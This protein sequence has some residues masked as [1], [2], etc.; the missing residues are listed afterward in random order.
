MAMA[1]TWEGIARA[2][3]RYVVAVSGAVG[4]G[5]LGGGVWAGTTTPTGTVLVSVGGAIVAASALALISVTREDLLETLLREGVEYVFK[6]RRTYCN[7]DFWDS[8]L[9]STRGHYRVL[10]VANHAYLGTQPKKDRFE[11]LFRAAVI[12]GVTVELLWLNP[13][14]SLAEARESEEGRA[15]R[16]DITEAIL[17][18]WSLKN[19]LPHEANRR[20]VLKEY[21]FIPSCGMTWADGQLIVTHYV[22]G[23]EN[24]DSP[25]WVLNTMPYPLY[26]RLLATIHVSQPQPSPLAQA[27]L[28][29]Y[30]EVEVK[31]TPIS[32]DRIDE[33]TERWPEFQAVGKPSE[34]KLREERDAVEDR[35]HEP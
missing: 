8:L 29:T 1:G 35:T 6:S 10:G 4:A 23:Q 24:L 15:T 14:T 9:R 3:R 2:I 21:V 13:N 16:S 7:D 33:L 32:Q 17:W 20:L 22:V 34:A 27:Y 26:R 12:R 19:S 28:D 30:R 25:G 5:L 18:F 31:S 11:P